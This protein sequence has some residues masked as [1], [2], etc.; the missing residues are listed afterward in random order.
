MTERRGRARRRVYSHQRCIHP[1]LQQRLGH[2]CRS[3]GHPVPLSVLSAIRTADKS[4]TRTMREL[5]TVAPVCGAQRAASDVM[6]N[7]NNW[8]A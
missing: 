8:T 3:L 2:Q 1:V 7:R 4:I 6:R 5:P